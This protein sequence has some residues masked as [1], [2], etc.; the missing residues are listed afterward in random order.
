MEITQMK[1]IIFMMFLGAAGGLRGAQDAAEAEARKKFFAAYGTTG[2]SNQLI[3]ALRQGDKL[4][5]DTLF[6]GK[7][8][9][10]CGI[11][12]IY[13]HC[14]DCNKFV[15]KAIDYT[16][17]CS[18]RCPLRPGFERSH[19]GVRLAAW[20]WAACLFRSGGC[21]KEDRAR[22]LIPGTL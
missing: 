9:V 3:E 15:N 10:I 17:V 22:F 16:G 18:P 12:S 8:Q 1:K 5:I 21:V 14:F 6:G 2:T 20:E 4:E 19:P 11:S 13:K 7:L